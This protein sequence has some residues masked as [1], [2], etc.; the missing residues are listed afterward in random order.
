MI[1]VVQ[2]QVIGFDARMEPEE[3]NTYGIRLREGLLGTLSVDHNIWWSVIEDLDGV[4]EWRGP[5]Q[6]LWSDLGEMTDFRNS[7]V[8]DLPPHWLIAFTHVLDPGLTEFSDANRSPYEPMN[9]ST[10]DPSWRFLGHDVAD[11]FLWSGISNCGIGMLDEHA[12]VVEEFG[13]ELNEFHLFT[14]LER[15]FAFR[16]HAETFV[17]EHA[18]FYVYG[19][20]RVE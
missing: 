15:A 6:N 4:P 17:G 10:I 11:Y 18:P 12:A 3:G 5:Y 2:E 1:T 9:P 19:M 8:G 7:R 13:P 20:Y 14:D 16:S